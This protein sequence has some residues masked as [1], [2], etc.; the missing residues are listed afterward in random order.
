M[1][2]IRQPITELKMAAASFPPTALVKMTA[3]DTGGGMQPTVIN[4]MKVNQMHKY[5]ISGSCHKNI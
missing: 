5:N 2:P 3:D 1:T 4:L